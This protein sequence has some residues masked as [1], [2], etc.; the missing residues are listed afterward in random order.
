MGDFGAAHGHLGYICLEVACV[1]ELLNMPLEFH[2]QNSLAV[3]G[4]FEGH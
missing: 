4:L 1:S 3:V 2:Q